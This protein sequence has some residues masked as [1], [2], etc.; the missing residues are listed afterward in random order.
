MLPPLII[1]N[2]VGMNKDMTKGVPEEAIFSSSPKG[3]ISSEM[4]YN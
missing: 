1:F 3:F 4:V 2:G